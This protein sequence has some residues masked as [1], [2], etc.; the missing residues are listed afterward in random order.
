MEVIVNFIKLLVSGV[1]AI[2]SFLIQL[3]SVLAV[4]VQ[5]FPPALS[6]LLLSCFG[7]IIAVRLLE[8]LP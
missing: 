8:L 5:A 4:C 2:I 3:P 7:L 1:Q 6:V